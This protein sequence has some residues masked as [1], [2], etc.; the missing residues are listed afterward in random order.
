MRRAIFVTVA[1][2]ALTSEVRSDQVWN[3]ADV[4]RNLHLAATIARASN[5]RRRSAA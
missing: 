5:S 3:A 1:R 4:V 2:C